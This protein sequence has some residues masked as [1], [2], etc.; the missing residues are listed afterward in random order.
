MDVTIC[1]NVY[2]VRMIPN[3]D[4]NDKDGD[5]L[6]PIIDWI[7]ES[8]ANWIPPAMSNCRHPQVVDNAGNL[9]CTICASILF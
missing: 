7:P 4:G 2:S 6:P 1:H 8:W 5:P 9:F 3:P